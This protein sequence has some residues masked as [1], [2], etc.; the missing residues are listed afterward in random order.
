MRKLS[1]NLE[2]RPTGQVIL[3]GS[4]FI[5]LLSFALMMVLTVSW[6]TH[7]RIRIQHA[8]DAQAYSQAV[9]TARA[10]NYIAY[11]NRAAAGALVSMAILSSYESEASAAVDLWWSHGVINIVAMGCEFG[12]CCSCPWGLCCKLNHCW[13]AFEDLATA[14]EFFASASDIASDVQ[15]LDTPFKKAMDGFQTMVKTI[16]LWNF[17]VL[18][19]LSAMYTAGGVTDLDEYNLPAGV[20]NPNAGG[21][22]TAVNLINNSVWGSVN[23]KDA[24][25]DE[26]KHKD[27]T[28]VANASRGGWTRGR[29]W[30]LEAPVILA[31][32]SLK[33]HGEDGGWW[34]QFQIGWG[35]GGKAGITEDGD[36]APSSD[37]KGNGI[38]SQ[39]FWYQAGICQHNCC[40][41]VN[42]EPGIWP[43]SLGW[44]W[45]MPAV[46]HTAADGNWE[47]DDN[48]IEGPHDSDDHE[49][50]V[51][52]AFTVY[53]IKMPD[54]TEPEAPYK[55][56]AIF[57]AAKQQLSVN[58]KGDPQPWM[59]TQ[60]GTQ[61]PKLVGQMQELNFK[62]GDNADGDMAYA[63]SKA[64][65]YYHRPGDWREPPS[66]WN[67]FWRAKL[68]PFTRGEAALVAGATGHGNTL[69]LVGAGAILGSGLNFS[70]D[71]H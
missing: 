47:H 61:K 59:I 33:I 28:E 37:I 48:M 53:T 64:L 16:K 31:P 67:P 15:E 35:L 20:A 5:L 44:G 34:V 39:D 41:N 9:H 29:N 60:S 2:R 62:G 52:K 10:F 42:G 68:H 56:P 11:S 55:Q 25:N 7:E 18:G 49:L 58:E 17:S 54:D 70:Q 27:M 30:G 36:L 19:L 6:A 22:I 23:G 8:A 32:L 12:I 43:I 24:T 13:H 66:F 21:M 57:A 26:R 51:D 69:Q 14:I 45:F 1:R 63:M 38:K 4:V 71:G 46:V 50:D 40:P 3:L 65:V